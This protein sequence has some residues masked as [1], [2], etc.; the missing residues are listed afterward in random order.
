MTPAL[1]RLRTAS[2]YTLS[3][4]AHTHILKQ[5]KVEEWREEPRHHGGHACK[6]STAGRQGQ[7]RQF[8]AIFD[9]VKFETRLHETLKETDLALQGACLKPW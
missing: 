2:S 9:C 1:R 3:V 8:E 4:R 7:E 5:N 6:V